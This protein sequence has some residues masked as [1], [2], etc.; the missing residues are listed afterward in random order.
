MN[1]S[2]LP[3]KIFFY[4]LLAIIAFFCLFPFYYGIITSFATGD[5]LFKVHY[6]PPSLS[7]QNYVDVFTSG[8]FG[9]SIVNSIMIFTTTVIGAMFLAVIAAYALARVHFRGR[10]LLLMTI[11]SMSMFPPMAIL[12]ELYDNMAF[13]LKISKKHDEKTIQ[14]RVHEI[15]CILQ[16]EQ[17]LNR[18]PKELSGGQRQRV[19]IGRAITRKPRVFLLDELLSNLD[20]ALRS[21]T[22]LEIAKLHADIKGATMIYVTHDQVE[23]MTLADRICV[24]KDGV[25][26]QVGSPKE[27]YE[28]PESIFVAGFIGTPKMNFL[29]GNFAQ[30]YKCH[31]MGIRPEH[32][33][34]TTADNVIY[35]GTVV[36]QEYLGSDH[37]LFVDVDGTNTLTVRYDQQTEKSKGDTVYLRCDTRNVHRFDKTGRINQQKL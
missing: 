18:L 11:L 16:I 7:F 19:A 26:E 22:R 35:S 5:D 8:N 30:K 2:Y 15:A 10:R 9:R 21:D 14:D 32:L 1:L 29:D 33:T 37:Y 3:N 25:I 31:T 36:H 27:V 23:A 6:I 13:G 24:L 28:K 4:V 17:L 34:T 12:P 20:A